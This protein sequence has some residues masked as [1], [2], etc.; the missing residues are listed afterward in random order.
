MLNKHI[1]PENI[2]KVRKDRVSLHRFISK[3]N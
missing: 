2:I 1:I 3:Q